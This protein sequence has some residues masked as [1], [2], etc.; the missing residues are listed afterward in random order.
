[1]CIGVEKHLKAFDP[2]PPDLDSATVQFLLGIGALEVVADE[3][4]PEPKPA[5]EPK[6]EPKPEI[7]PAP[8]SKPVTPRHLGKKE[9]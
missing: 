9:K 5:P 3:P 4:K 2:V 8:A 7:D 1:V 6:Q